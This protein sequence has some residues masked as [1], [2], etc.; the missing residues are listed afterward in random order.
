MI[1]APAFAIAAVVFLSIT[2]LAELGRKLAVAWQS[3]TVELD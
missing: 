1:Y 3:R 2:I